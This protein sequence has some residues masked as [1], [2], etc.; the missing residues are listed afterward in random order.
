MRRPVVTPSATPDL[1]ALR[2]RRR[3]RALV[4]VAEDD[5]ALVQVV[6][7]HLH[8]DLVAGERADAVLLH[9]AGGVGDDF[10]IVLEA[11]AI[12]AV[13]QHIHDLA[14]ELKQ[15]FLGHASSSWL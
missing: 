8:G 4:L 11:D 2:R 5:A 9:A 10:V 14:V 7:R 12:A 15:L 1:M 6:G 13:R 3:R